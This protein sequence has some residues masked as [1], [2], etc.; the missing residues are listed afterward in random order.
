MHLNSNKVEF[1]INL[2]YEVQYNS[3]I[4]IFAPKI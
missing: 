1:T 4:F 3:I 2:Q